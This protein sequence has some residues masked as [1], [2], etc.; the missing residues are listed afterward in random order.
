MEV[1]HYFALQHV[2][3]AYKLW[4]KRK[5]EETQGENQKIVNMALGNMPFVKQN[6][7]VEKCFYVNVLKIISEG[8]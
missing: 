3:H 4:W 2:S 1:G 8:F 7:Y 5:R 6:F